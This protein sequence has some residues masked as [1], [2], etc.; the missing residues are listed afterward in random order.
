MKAEEAGK[1]EKE[2]KKIIDTPAPVVVA[3][4]EPTFEPAPG[5]GTQT[6]WKAEVTDI[7]ALCKAVSDGEVPEEY[8][9]PNMPFLNSAVRMTKADTKIPGVKAVKETTTVMR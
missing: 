5:I 2:I 3:P 7:K 6:R 1:S 9:L 4:V 8:V